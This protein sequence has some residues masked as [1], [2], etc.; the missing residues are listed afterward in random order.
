MFL[1]AGFCVVDQRKMSTVS[2]NHKG[3]GCWDSS[4]QPVCAG[5]NMA[6]LLLSELQKVLP[7][8]HLML[9]QEICI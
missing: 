8:D 1:R 6:Q 2:A 5:M 9:L 3:S 4:A 7:S